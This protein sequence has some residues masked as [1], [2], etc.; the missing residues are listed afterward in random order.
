MPAISRPAFRTSMHLTGETAAELI[1]AAK[2]AED[3]G[4]HTLF[5]S[6][7]YG[8]PFVPLAAVTAATERV[9]LGTGIALAFVRSPLAL[10]LEA[11]DMDAITSGRFVLGLGTGV[12]RL[13]EDWHGVEN[14]GGP[15]AHMREVIAFLRLF[16][17]RAHRGE[18]IEMDGDYVKAHIRGYR[19]PFKP[20][21]ERLP[22]FL[23]ANQPKMLELAGEV[24]DGVL[25]H[26]FLSERYLRET[27]LP[28]I[29]K[30]LKKSGRA[31]T[32]F[33][34]G[35]GLI[36]AIDDR[37][38]ALARRHAAGVLAF[39]ATVRTYAPIFASDGFG[40]NAARARERFV[41]GD[42][43]GAIDAITEEMVD[44][45]CAA[46]TSDDALRRARRY[47]GLID[48]LGIGPPR[49]LC[50]PE[51]WAGYRQRMLAVFGGA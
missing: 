25:G 7:L 40:E 51:L 38:P 36:C 9:R 24:A 33:E 48:T 30:G 1:E 2:E 35:A 17:E 21:A 23:G 34:I 50:P 6:E 26:V 49:H 5:A 22:I 28:P 47:E 18:S 12:R 43:E 32:D 11:F 42:P 37:D 44:T 14:F 29:E 39:Y 31:R 10:A 19:R 8:N 27:F 46:G 16:E 20:K 41:A 45:Y 15:V 4:V 3:A 13:N